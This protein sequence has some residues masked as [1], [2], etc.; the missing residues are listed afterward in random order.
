MKRSIYKI[1][2][3][4]SAIVWAIF[5]GVAW[6]TKLG[7]GIVTTLGGIALMFAWLYE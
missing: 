1:S 2:T 4:M 5:T 7:L 3:F 6:W